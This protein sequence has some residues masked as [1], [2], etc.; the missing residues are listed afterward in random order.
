LHAFD[1]GVLEHEI[2]DEGFGYP[3]MRSPC[4]NPYG[5]SLLIGYVADIG[6]AFRSIYLETFFIIA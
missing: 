3:S 5:L 6:L 4:R 2:D 1:E